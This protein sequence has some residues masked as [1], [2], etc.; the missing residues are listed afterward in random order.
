MTRTS[1]SSTVWPS[2]QGACTMQ[3]CCV[4]VP[5]SVCSKIMPENPWMACCWVTVDTCSVTGCLPH[6]PTCQPHNTCGEELQCQTHVCSIF[7]GK[8]HRCAEA[9]FPVIYKYLTSHLAFSYT[10]PF[11]ASCIPNPVRVYTRLGPV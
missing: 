7:C 10:F 11:S 6:L 5:C 4:K 8:K 9:V 1:S 3:G 2:G